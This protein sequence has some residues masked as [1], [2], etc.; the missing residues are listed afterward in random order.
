MGYMRSWP[1]SGT[2]VGRPPSDLPNTD[3]T[4]RIGIRNV[5]ANGSGHL[6]PP[7]DGCRPFCTNSATV[8]M[9]H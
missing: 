4:R 6:C 5:A 3:G 8:L 2:R 9:K 1:L 7:L